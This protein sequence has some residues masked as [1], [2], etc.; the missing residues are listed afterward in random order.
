[1]RQRRITRRFLLASVGFLPLIAAC[2]GDGFQY[3]ISGDRAET[4]QRN[5]GGF[6]SSSSMTQEATLKLQEDYAKKA[7]EAEAAKG[8]AGG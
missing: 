1:M 8:A 4:E 2:G 6:G 3:K 7:Q 5:A